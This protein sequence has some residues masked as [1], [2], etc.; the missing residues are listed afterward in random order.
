M[1]PGRHPADDPAVRRVPDRHPFVGDD[2][3]DAPTSPTQVGLSGA[4]VDRTALP[5][6]GSPTITTDGAVFEDVAF[7][8]RVDVDGADD[9]TF[10]RCWLRGGQFYGVLFRNGAGAA[11]FV[12]CDLG[13][14]GADGWVETA[15]VAGAAGHTRIVRCDLHNAGDAV[16]VGG[17]STTDVEECWVQPVRP[18][19]SGQHVDCLQIDDN[20]VAELY[21]VRSTLE[22]RTF[23][24]DG[25]VDHSRNHL[26]APLSSVG[27][28]HYGNS[29]LQSKPCGDAGCDGPVAGVFLSWQ[30]CLMTGGGNYVAN[31]HSQ[32]GEYA[33]NTVVRWSSGGGNDLGLRDAGNI[34]ISGNRFHDGGSYG[35][36]PVD[37]GDDAA[38]DVPIPRLGL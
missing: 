18:D 23:T 33:D 11:T 37:V 21:V 16:K 35:G 12:D 17:G 2:G 5:D 20:L 27:V 13:E 30:D 28:D 24:V 15:L 29:I 26:D 32:D 19:G 9:V 36:G 6:V 38:R 10:R 4:G 14:P 31:C 1:D 8:G 22:A 34:A 3:A 25:A 7:S